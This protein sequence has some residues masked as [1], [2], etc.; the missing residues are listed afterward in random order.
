MAKVISSAPLPS[1]FMII[2]IIGFI[3]SALYW[4]EVGASWAFT[5]MLF[6]IILFTASLVS[7]KQSLEFERI[8]KKRKATRRSKPAK[9]VKKK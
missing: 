8:R 5:F 1:S 2:G 6:C 3:A 9:R 7:L 4:D